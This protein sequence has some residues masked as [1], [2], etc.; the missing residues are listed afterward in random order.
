M[1]RIRT[2]KPEFPH[3]ETVGKLSRD[4]RLL[5]VQLWTIVDDEGR[6]RAA[7]RMLAS[8]L[9]PY[10][11]DAPRL[12]EDWLNELEAAHCIRRYVVG[13]S[14]YLDL[15]TWLKHQKIDKPS[16]SK[17]PAF[18][19]ASPPPREDSRKVAPDLG[20]STMDQEGDLG[21]SS[22]RSEVGASAP[23][24]RPSATKKGTRISPDFQPD[25]EYA[26]S[27]GV[28]AHRQA[29]IAAKFIDYWLSKP[30]KDGV[31][32]DWQATWRNW[33]RTECER[34]NWFPPI[35]PA[36][37]DTPVREGKFI[38]VDTDDWHQLSGE[39]RQ[40]G[41]L[42]PP[43]IHTLNGKRGAYVRLSDTTKASAA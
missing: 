38:P 3:S 16:K 27:I 1:A 43:A 21:T 18:V 25:Y 26:T 7:S 31:K 6:A 17:L 33:C 5:F 29:G 39:M 34:N 36:V 20:P 24:A 13:G 8:L 42:M 4:A 37:V 2:I 30:G 12:M 22:L 11:D 15:P 14:Q 10:D 41:Q 23:D 40:R 19:E 9:Y 32:L 28:P 35:A